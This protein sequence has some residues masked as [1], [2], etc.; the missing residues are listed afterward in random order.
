MLFG[1]ATQAQTI[2]FEDDFESYDDFEYENVGDWTLVDADGYRDETGFA[3]VTFPNQN[4][5]TSFIVFNPNNTTPP[6]EDF[7][8]TFNWDFS[9]KSGEKYMLAK[10]QT[11]GA[12]DD[13]LISPQIDLPN[14][15]GM[16][17]NFSVKAP[18]GGIF[19]ET[20]NVLISTTDKEL[21]SFDLIDEQTMTVGK[22]WVEMEYDLDQY[23][24]ESIFVAIQYVSHGFFAFLID[25][26]KISAETLGINKHLKSEIAVF[27]NPT[28]DDFSI[29][30]PSHFNKESMKITLYDMAGRAVKSLN[31]AS[32]TVSD[33]PS[34]TYFL[35]ISDR[36]H[37]SKTTLIKK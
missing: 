5:M 10:F 13:W 20:F 34:A 27:P 32:L 8:G 19:N 4:E 17:L 31:P 9:A 23:Q 11:S 26:F 1:M 18:S 30:I 2:I 14:G 22:E 21:E 35:E 25:D 15:T 28:K 3:M 16:K 7:N 24:G 29:S 37:K 12:N 33:L 36:K 6:M